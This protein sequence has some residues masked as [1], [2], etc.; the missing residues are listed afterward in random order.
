MNFDTS[1]KNDDRSQIS[2]GFTLVELL[3][4]IAIIGVLIALL[5]PAVQAARESA[6]R[7]QCQSQLKQLALGCMN[8]HDVHGHFPTGGW[9]WFWAGDPDRGAGKQQPGGW[10]YNVLPYIEQAQLHQLGSDGQP[11]VITAGQR[12]GAARLIETPFPLIICPSRRGTTSHVIADQLVDR[13]Y[14]AD[15][16]TE[17][18]R[19]DYA[20]NSGTYFNQV[21]GSDVTGA[22][23]GGG[24]RSLDDD[25]FKWID[26]LLDLRK[27][28]DRLDGI[29]S[30][31]SVIKIAQITDGT[32]NTLMLGE[33][34]HFPT[35]Y[36]S[37]ESGGDN[38]TW[39]T[40]FN[41]D[42]Y[43]GMIGRV[44]PNGLFLGGPRSDSSAEGEQASR[45]N[46]HMKAFGSAHPASW[47]G[48]LCDGSVRGLSY[49]MDP[50]VAKR[51][52]N[53]FDGKVIDAT[54]L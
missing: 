41:N 2:P 44:F 11:D 40:G 10:I 4:V 7:T 14:N 6:R 52:A 24:P 25:R 8:T 37:G 46:T 20:A 42:L 21:G 33:K 47:H 23:N 49:E 27:Q 16:P 18:G 12:A 34:A 26:D 1:K 39:C 35:A 31:R 48:A 30:Q 15:P 5:L 17:A 45:D 13:F 9:G 38:E 43:R 22:G 29:F 28:S 54:E 32:S 3:V 19:A 51:L 50:F 36:E 53:R